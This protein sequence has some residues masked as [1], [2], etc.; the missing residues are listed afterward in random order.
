MVAV[1]TTSR[2]NIDQFFFLL[3]SDTL[4]NQIAMEL[5]PNDYG[6]EYTTVTGVLIKVED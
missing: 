4:E 5:T 6:T 3:S 1:G 2:Q